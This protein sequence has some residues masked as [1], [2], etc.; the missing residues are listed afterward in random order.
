M[1]ACTISKATKSDLKKPTIRRRGREAGAK[2]TEYKNEP[3]NKTEQ[4]KAESS[5]FFFIASDLLE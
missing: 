2:E 3:N 1:C 5:S 4:Q